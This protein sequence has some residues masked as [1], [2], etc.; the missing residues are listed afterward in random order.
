[1]RCHDGSRPSAPVVEPATHG[2]HRLDPAYLA[3]GGPDTLVLRR[4]D[5][6]AIAKQG[7]ECVNCHM[8]QTFY[9]QRHRRHDHGFTTPDPLMTERHGIPNACNR[10]HADRNT[11][12]AGRAVERW[13]GARM[14][15]PSRQRTEIVARA[16]RGDASVADS[17]AARVGSETASYWRAVASSLLGTLTA[18]SP[19]LAGSEAALVAATRDPSP[20]VRTAAAMA[21]EPAAEAGDRAARASLEPLLRDPVRNVRYQA[22]WTLRGSL[23]PD[24]PATAE[25]RAVLEFAADEPLGR[26]RIGAWQAARGALDSAA[27]SYR[28]AASWDTNSA[29]LRH[30]LAILLARLGKN[31][32]AVIE[33]LA[34]CRHEPRVAEYP[35]KLGL[36][37]NEVGHRDLAIAAFRDAVRLDPAHARAWYDLGL[38]LDAE[39][40]SDEALRSLGRAERA[41]P[42]SPDAPY[43]RATI[44]ARSGRVAEARRAAEV[45]LARQ[46]GYRPA[47][48]LLGSLR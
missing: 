43:A 12:W 22:A 48:E 25:T 5:P 35:F 23:A 29:P 11:K 37:W 13:Y 6:E 17:L 20:L 41:D 2:H 46:P 30:D 31:D 10:C 3:P 32:E 1:M 15:R 42:R 19:G 28:I 38:A 9:M 47:E 33:L 4:R 39:G 45:A 8:P 36:A 14:N 27:A 18:G 26:M 24:D 40:E 21:L 34:A 44:L 7:G 16:R